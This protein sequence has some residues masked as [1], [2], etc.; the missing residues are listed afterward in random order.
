MLPKDFNVDRM[1]QY[2]KDAGYNDARHLRHF[3]D[4]CPTEIVSRVYINA[5]AE[6]EAYYDLS[7]DPMKHGLFVFGILEEAFGPM[8]D[9][10][11]KAIMERVAQNGREI[12]RPMRGPA[13][14]VDELRALNM[15]NALATRHEI[16][17]AVLAAVAAATETRIDFP[18]M[19][20]AFRLWK[21][22]PER[23]AFGRSLRRSEQ[24]AQFRPPPGVP[25][26]MSMEEYRNLKR[27]RGITREALN[28]AIIMAQQ[29]LAGRLTA[30]R[31]HKMLGALLRFRDSL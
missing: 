26:I 19:R 3:T 18:T 24:V 30:D 29:Q 9:E 21:L 20:Q 6:T 1:V 12:V 31:A 17:G 2:L 7:P 23:G 5:N 14:S 25:V 13:L 28:I 15:R 27:D 8:L 16:T 22:E 10:T 11:G 4:D